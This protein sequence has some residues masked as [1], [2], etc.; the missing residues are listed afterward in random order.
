MLHQQDT[1]RTITI[2]DYI[3]VLAKRRR[4]I[5]LVTVAAC[6]VSLIYSLFL[7]NVYTARALLLPAQEDK[8]L[9]N[10]MMSQIGGLSL[11]A[12]GGIGGTTTSDLYVSMLK[13]ETIKDPIIEQFK[14]KDVYNSNSL[15]DIYATLDKNV[16][17]VAGK[18]DSIVTISVEDHNPKR[19][20]EIANAYV[21]ELQKLTVA[22]NISGAG[23]NRT[24]LQDRL[25]KAKV[26]LSTAEEALKTFQSKNKSINVTEQVKATIGGV[27]QLRAELALQEVKLSTLRRTLTD[28]NQ[29]VKNLATSIEYLKRQ[30]EKMEG[31]SGG[32]AIPSIGSM[33]ALGQEYVRLFREVKIQETLVE[34]LTRQY[35]LA[36]LSEAKDLST[37]QVL[38]HAKAPDKKSKPKRALLVSI[39]TFSA[40]IFSI[41]LAFIIESYDALPPEEKARLKN[42]K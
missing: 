6:L 38:Q 28:S 42:L 16:S 22:L 31:N 26:D 36:R 14:L 25:A 1:V 5:F 17:I 30:I 4:M 15:T 10:A 34:I 7:H 41:F 20:A 40:F 8:G 3:R 27:A 21:M 11:L 33:P 29:K 24:F 35:E 18:K 23:Q 2:I 39:T 13:S 19:A 37:F 12:G 32:S 9:M